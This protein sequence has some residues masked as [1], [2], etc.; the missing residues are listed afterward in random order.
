M[1]RLLKNKKPQILKST[2][3]AK[4]AIFTIEG[5]DLRFSNGEERCYERVQGGAR[6]SVL[7]VPLLDAETMLLIREYAAGVD[8]Y[9][10]AFPKG[11]IASGEDAL[12]TA[13]REL[14]E[15]A[16][17]G[18]T[19]LTLLGRVSA[20][21]GYMSSM[22]DIVLAQELY[23]AEAVG[24]EPE[25]IEVIPWQLNKVDAL[26][27]HPAFHEARSLAALLLLERH[28]RRE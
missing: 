19:T 5:L 25:P 27:T 28:L 26:I 3:L 8:D 6:G 22:M 18:A 24:D 2:I 15:E 7:I 9:L 10:L 11:A 20:A 16:G 13:Q 4:T 14:Q 17:Y 12:S 1:E 23:P 21:P